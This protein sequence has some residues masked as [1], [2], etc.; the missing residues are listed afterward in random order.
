MCRVEAAASHSFD[1]GGYYSAPVNTFSGSIY[2]Y[3]VDGKSVYATLVKIYAWSG[4]TNTIH[5][6]D[7]HTTGGDDIFTTNYN[8]A[9]NTFGLCKIQY[10][11][12]DA[13]VLPQSRLTSTSSRLCHRTALSESLARWS[14]IRSPAVGAVGHITFASLSGFLTTHSR[15]LPTLV[16]PRSL[17]CLLSPGRLF[18]IPV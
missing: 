8:K 14:S 13:P 18:S 3:N 12:K 9:S 1:G 11:G 17:C 6:G 7:C 5:E 16:C 15:S 2:C 10:A 4:N